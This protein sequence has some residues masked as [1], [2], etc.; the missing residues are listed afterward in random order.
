MERRTASGPLKALGAS[1]WSQR[2]PTGRRTSNATPFSLGS[3]K[4]GVN[5]SGRP[6][7]K[8]PAARRQIRGPFCCTAE[9]PGWM[10]SAAV[11][12]SAILLR[13]RGSHG[14]AAEL[15][16]FAL[17]EPWRPRR[18]PR[19][20]MIAERQND[21][22][23]ALGDMGVGVQKGDW[24]PATCDWGNAG[25]CPRGPWGTRRTD[26]RVVLLSFFC[27][28]WAWLRWVI[29]RRQTIGGSAPIF[30]SLRLPGSV[31]YLCTLS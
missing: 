4:T 25:R 7:C 10:R 24:R 29:G 9:R 6:L 15:P 22:D 18:T 20:A 11:L 1:S 21:G 8:R 12:N 23:F 28:W 5:K 17:W 13:P 16:N 30:T 31:I 26:G 3:P 19:S 14:I 2:T 27:D